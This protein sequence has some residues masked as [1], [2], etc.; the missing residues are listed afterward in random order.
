MKFPM[1]FGCRI[2]EDEC[3]LRKI[4]SIACDIKQF[5]DD[6]IK[7]GLSSNTLYDILVAIG[8]VAYSVGVFNVELTFGDCIG[9]LALSIKTPFTD[10]VESAKD[11]LKE[12]VNYLKENDLQ[13]LYDINP[14]IKVL[15]KALNSQDRLPYTKG[16]SNKALMVEDGKYS[17]IE[18][19]D[20][21][22]A[23]TSDAEIE[24]RST[25]YL[26]IPGLDNTMM[27]TGYNNIL[28]I[29]DGDIG[30]AIYLSKEVESF[31]D[32]IVDFMDNLEYPDNKQPIYSFPEV[33]LAIKSIWVIFSDTEV[34]IGA[35]YYGNILDLEY[36]C[37]KEDFW[38][39]N[40]PIKYNK[41]PDIAR[42]ILYEYLSMGITIN[43]IHLN[44]VCSPSTEV[45]CKDFI[46]RK[47]IKGISRNYD[48]VYW[49]DFLIDR[50]S[51]IATC[52][53]VTDNALN[54]KNEGY[55]RYL[56]F[57][58]DPDVDYKRSL[59][60]EVKG[61]SDYI[62]LEEE[63]SDLK[64]NTIDEWLEYHTSS[65]ELKEGLV[66]ILLQADIE[67][68]KDIRTKCESSVVSSESNGYSND[69]SCCVCGF[70]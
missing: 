63:W 66:Y 60:V 27:K 55:F 39:G 59:L 6:T 30:E 62:N 54:P 1:L 31:D 29:Y 51:Y 68:V 69:G 33:E 13:Y 15:D 16:N 45:N 40:I 8:F 19:Y 26:N 22:I 44:N 2:G 58:H 57:D 64:F 52:T 3:T 24:Y 11:R 56:I 65:S 5:S 28:S 38:N 36:I 61:L 70:A 35:Y 50:K 53:M 14:C 23:N 25:H 20:H 46:Y 67:R 21:I 17:C 4:D 48:S 7:K 43:A 37:S 41:L 49:R 12:V 47:Y 34:S 9:S 32:N 18:G 10:L 42:S